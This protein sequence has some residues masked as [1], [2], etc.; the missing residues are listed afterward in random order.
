L[1]FAVGVNPIFQPL[2]LR[3][4]NCWQTWDVI[5]FYLE[6]NGSYH[7]G[8]LTDICFINPSTCFTSARVWNGDGAVVK[9]ED[10]GETWEIIYWTDYYCLLAIDFPS[11][12]IGYVT[13]NYGIICKT[14]DGGD[15]W[16]LVYS[17]N[18]INVLND[19]SFP[20]MDIGTAVGSVGC[21]LRTEDGGDSWELQDSGV[22]S[23][24]NAVYFVDPDIGY[25]VGND[26]IVL[27]TTDGGDT[28]KLLILNPKDSAQ[29]MKLFLQRLLKRS[30][31]DIKNRTIGLL[32]T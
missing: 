12:D 14:S 29:Q 25:I 8:D 22:D 9:T 28:W 13:G 17:N 18:Q 32:A 2:V 15:N 6:H 21:I 26:G 11:S 10:C 4:N 31:I 7:E 23:T 30:F 24:L 20:T 27:K 5:N 16:E 3:T 1:G 19:V